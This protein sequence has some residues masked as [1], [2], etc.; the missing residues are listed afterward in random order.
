MLGTFDTQSLQVTKH[1]N[2]TVCF[3]CSFIRNTA[4]IGCKLLIESDDHLNTCYLSQSKLFIFNNM[5]E[6]C[7]D[8]IFSGNYAILVYDIGVDNVSSF[9]PAISLNMVP[10]KG[11][12]CLWKGS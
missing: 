10:I 2:N 8:G 9:L 11:K 5:H 7:F 1:F 3:D 4:A 6:V 12:D